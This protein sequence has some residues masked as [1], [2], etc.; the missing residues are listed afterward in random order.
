MLIGVEALRISIG[1]ML[2]CN[3]Y[4][5]F[6]ANKFQELRKDRLSGKKSTFVHVGMF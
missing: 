1:L 2:F 4:Y 3:G 6:F 5:N